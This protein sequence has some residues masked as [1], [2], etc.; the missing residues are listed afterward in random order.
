MSGNVSNETLKK[1]ARKASEVFMEDPVYKLVSKNEK[2]RKT[3]IYHGV[4]IRLYDS[5][6]NG[7]LFYFDR[8]ERGLLVLRKVVRSLQFSQFMK[9][10]N[11]MALFMLLPYVLKLFSIIGKF[12]SRGVFGDDSYMISPI[13]V[14][15][16]HQ[17]KGVASALVKKAA[18][19]ILP[20]GYKICLDTQ[21]PDN[22][23]K[24]K[25]MGFRL[26]K[27]EYYEEDRLH[28]YYMVM[29]QE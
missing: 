3:V 22:V 20:A 13:F 1:Y 12:D 4:L 16:E 6:N 15:K 18:A 9:C 2:I 19:D 24:Y 21:N 14:A 11:F 27:E 10:P 8:E 26:A 23:E 17:K 29:E 25:K 7:D 5:R 28:N